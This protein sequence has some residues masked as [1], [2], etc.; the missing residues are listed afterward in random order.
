MRTRHVSGWAGGLTLALVLGGTLPAFGQAF[1]SGSTGALGALAP[2]ANTTVTLPP[3]GILHYTTVT[4]PSGVT[5]TFARNA[6]NT[7]V[8][9]LAQGDVTI[10]GAIQVNGENAV[11]GATSG[12]WEPTRGRSGGPG[13]YDGGDG[14]VRGQTPSNGTGGQGPGGGGPGLLPAIFTGD[15]SYGASGTFVTLV[16][17]FGGSGGGG[18]VGTTTQSGAAGAGGG[19]ALVIASTTQITIQ[20]TGSIT[21]NGGAG[22]VP[23]TK[24]GGGAGSGGAIRLVAPEITHAGTVQAKGGNPSCLGGGYDG[25]PGRIRIECTT[26]SLAATIPSASVVDQLGP[27]T[28]A[29]TPPLVNLPMLA[30]STVGGLAVPASPTGA[31][32]APDLAMPDAT[33]NPITVTLTANHLPVPMTF[34]VKVIPAFGEPLFFP[35]TLSTGSFAASTATA[36]LWLPPGSVSVLTASASFTQVAGLFPPIEGEAVEQ[37][38]VA[39]EAG[40]PSVTSVRTTSGKAIPVTQLAPDTQRRVALALATMRRPEN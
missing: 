33:A 13:G 6:A 34:V 24:T 39:A 15:G 40:A 3:D 27:I 30:I 38:L 11:V 36:A 5:V 28:A 1:N 29:S 18:G 31:H 32:A 20:S 8:T 4:I 17:L 22:Y 19:G 16:P 12:T 2:A 37:I 14:G 25:D 26:C 21:A 23:C 10:A 35:S 9:L 7:P